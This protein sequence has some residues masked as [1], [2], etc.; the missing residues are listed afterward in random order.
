MLLFGEE[1]LPKRE[2]IS[3]ELAERSSTKRRDKQRANRG[4]GAH[5]SGRRRP[6]HREDARVASTRTPRTL[7]HSPQHQLRPVRVLHEQRRV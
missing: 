7:P 5:R 1:N 2:T 4:R 6:I 3:I